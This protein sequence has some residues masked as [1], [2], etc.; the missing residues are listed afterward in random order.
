MNSLTE[1]NYLKAIYKLMEAGETGEITT[2]AIADEVQTKAATVT[3]MLKKLSNKKLINYK[4]YQGVTLTAKGSKAALEIVRKHRLWEVFLVDKLNFKW[5]EVHIIAE[6]LE[7]INS[8]ELVERLDK[9]L[10]Y[11]KFDP[12]GDPIPDV[13]GKLQQKN[14]IHLSEGKNEGVYVMTGVA[15][16]D[17]SFLRFLDKSGIALGKQIK[18]KEIVEYDKSLNISIDKKPG[19]YISNE[20]AKN[21]LVKPV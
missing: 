12:H 8:D 15:D 4:K 6:Q 18:V 13:N 20:V 11:P 1:E 9:F 14:S 19:I 2:N 17:S 10:N 16:H 21:I 5:D 7:H 3:D